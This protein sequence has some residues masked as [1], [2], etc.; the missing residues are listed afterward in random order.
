MPNKKISAL[1]AAGTL[2]ETELM[3]LVQSGVNVQSTPGAI[4]G[5]AYRGDFD[6]TGDVLPTSGGRTGGVPQKGD[7][8]KLTGAAYKTIAEGSVLEANQ[9]NP[10]TEAHWNFYSVQI[11]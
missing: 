2:T 8:W 7:R 10:T 9:D 5:L 11:P 1:A 4:A 3:E 6:P